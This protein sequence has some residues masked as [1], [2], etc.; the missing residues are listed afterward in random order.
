MKSVEENIEALSG[1]ILS[2]AKAEAEQIGSDAGTKAETIRQRAKEQAEAERKEILDRASQEADRIRSQVVSTTQLKART[3]ELESREKLLDGVFKA[4]GQQLASIQQ[5]PDY[6]QIVYRLTQEAL[7]QLNVKDGQIRADN[8]TQKLLADHIS[9]KI[10]ADMKITLKIGQPLEGGTGVVVD[11]A[12]G[13][14][15]YD[16]TL[17]TRLSRLQNGLRSAV[18]R[19]LMG[20]SQ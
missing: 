6:D 13:H 5:R 7:S 11:T 9:E 20:E 3:M 15:H 17:E 18:N 8:A 16:N 14:L 2:E 12:D 4:A 1:A 10:C 19:I